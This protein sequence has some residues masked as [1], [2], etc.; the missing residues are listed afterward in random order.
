MDDRV[1]NNELADIDRSIY[2]VGGHLAISLS[3]RPLIIRGT[4]FYTM[5]TGNRF[6]RSSYPSET[7]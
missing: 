4:A 7:S 5:D 1:I 2:A 6:N 3:S